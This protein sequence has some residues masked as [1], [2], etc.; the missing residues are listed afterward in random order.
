ML[1]GNANLAENPTTLTADGGGG[2]PVEVLGVSA[3]ATTWSPPT[4]GTFAG[5]VQGLGTSTGTV[6]GIDG[7][8][9]GTHGAGVYGLTDSGYG[10]MGDSNTGIGLYAATSGRIRKRARFWQDCPVTRPTSS[11]KFATRT[12][13]CGSTTCSESGTV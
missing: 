3:A 12:V 10:V 9:G 2:V 6:E 13:C 1:L 4:T 11:S 8:A 5:P 7:W